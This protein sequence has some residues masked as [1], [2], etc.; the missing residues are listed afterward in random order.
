MKNNIKICKHTINI[1]FIIYYLR[2]LILF[3]KSL[4]N[5]KTAVKKFLQF[6]YTEN[7]HR[8]MMK[9]CE[10][11]HIFSM[12]ELFALGYRDFHSS[13]VIHYFAFDNALS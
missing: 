13:F 9:S 12:H 1:K 6:V 5:L 11:P 7:L 4:V 10:S 2:N 8:I 3:T